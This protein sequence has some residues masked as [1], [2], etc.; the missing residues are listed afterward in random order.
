[1]G[2]IEQPYD[3]ERIVRQGSI[4]TRRSVWDRGCIQAW[5]VEPTHGGYVLTVELGTQRRLGGELLLASRRNWVF[6][7]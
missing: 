7:A 2:A 6:Q 4:W 1:M 3:I 5:G